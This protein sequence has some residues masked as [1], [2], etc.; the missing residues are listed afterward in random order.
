MTAHDILKQKILD[1]EDGHT[2]GITRD[3]VLCIQAKLES[4]HRELV[5]STDEKFVTKFERMHSCLD[6][7]M[8]AW[9]IETGGLLSKC[10]LIEFAT[11]SY[12]RTSDSTSGR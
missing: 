12:G 2:T 3:E 4:L 8:A 1:T 9:L 5:E 6:E 7:M 11:W 10:N